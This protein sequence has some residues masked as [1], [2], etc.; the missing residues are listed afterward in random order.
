MQWDY[1]TLVLEARLPGL[2]QAGGEIDPEKLDNELNRL[3]RQG[4]ELV[5]SFP[6][7]M[8][9]GGTRDVVLI[10]KRPRVASA[11]PVEK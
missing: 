2:F 8:A 6:I 7:A 4:W 1:Y 11:V 9:E 3:G 5:G 10:F